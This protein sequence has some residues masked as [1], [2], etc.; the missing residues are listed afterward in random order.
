MGEIQLDATDL[1]FAIQPRMAC[2]IAS[3][4]PTRVDTAD[5]TCSIDPP[6]VWGLLRVDGNNDVNSASTTV[7]TA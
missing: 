5:R 7:Y 4:T 2:E 3:P 6:G 1:W